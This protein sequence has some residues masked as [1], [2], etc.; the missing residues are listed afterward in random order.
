MIKKDIF[1]LELKLATLSGISILIIL[2]TICLTKITS[3]INSTPEID[4]LKITQLLACLFALGLITLGI[5]SPSKKTKD[6]PKKS[7]PALIPFHHI[8]T[9]KKPV[10]IKLKDQHGKSIKFPATKIIKKPRRIKPR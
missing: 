3:E 2:T 9:T 7:V 1:K 8:K 5:F 4:Y 6:S 10:T